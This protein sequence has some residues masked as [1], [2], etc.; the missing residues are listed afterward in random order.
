LTKNRGRQ[1]YKAVFS[2]PKKE[3]KVKVG[4]HVFGQLAERILDGGAYKA[5]KYFGDKLT[6]KATRKLFKYNGRKVDNRRKA[7]EIMF[8]IGPP[9][10]EEREF[11]KKC[12]AAGEALPVKKIQVKFPK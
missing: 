5:T 11:I 2:R 10:Y 3:N 8:T 7:V 4:R 12:F 9:N 1:P 6:V